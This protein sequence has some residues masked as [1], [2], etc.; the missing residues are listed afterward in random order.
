MNLPKVKSSVSRRSFLQLAGVAASMPILTE[1]HFAYAA[2][3][4]QQPKAGAAP[5]RRKRM[6]P[7]PGDCGYGPQGR[8]V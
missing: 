3:D 1:A 5:V 8:P 6:G 7:V 4:P 2:L